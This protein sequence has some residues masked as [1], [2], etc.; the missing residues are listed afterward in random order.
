MNIEELFDN[1]KWA[2]YGMLTTDDANLAIDYLKTEVME[3][4]AGL[5]KELA[6]EARLNG[7]GAEREAKLLARVAELEA[8]NLN[9]MALFRDFYELEFNRDEC[10]E[11][12]K[13]YGGDA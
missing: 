2:G 9:M 12:I 1:E 6:E 4:V 13:K 5:Q 3:Y 11:I 7:M 8:Q 10:W